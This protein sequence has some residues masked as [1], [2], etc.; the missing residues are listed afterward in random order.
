MQ[1]FMMKDPQQ[2]MKYMQAMQGAGN[3]ANAAVAASVADSAKIDR[4]LKDHTTNLQA[5]IAK[6]LDPTRAAIK[7]LVDAKAL[8]THES[9]IFAAA[10]DTARFEALQEQLNT[11]YEKLC[12]PWWG[13]AGAFQVWMRSYKTYLVNDIIT[14][15]EAVTGAVVLQM[16][17][18]DTPTGGYRS[19][20][21]LENVRKYMV[22][23]REVYNLRPRGKFGNA[24]VPKR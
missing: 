15:D 19:T 23:A 24:S 22:K 21:L 6:T 16:A 9:I 17:I 13:A 8:P 4:D 10:A 18:M 14:P 2:A 12:V 20:V 5:A 3:T 11:D 1:A 7:Q